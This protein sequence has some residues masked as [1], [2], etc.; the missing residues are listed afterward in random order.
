MPKYDEIT[1]AITD[2]CKRRTKRGAKQKDI[3]KLLAEYKE[4]WK[5]DD[6][7]CKFIDILMLEY[8]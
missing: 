2:V 7:I 3:L 6:K 1:K 8:A 4:Y 5:L